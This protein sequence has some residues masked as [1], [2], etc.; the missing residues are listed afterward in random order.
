MDEEDSTRGIKFG[1]LVMEG[2]DIGTNVFLRQISNI[3]GRASGRALAP[4]AAEGIHENLA[5]RDQRI[6]NGLP[7]R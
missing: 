4:S 5:A 1:N 6:A 3:P 7:R 2:R